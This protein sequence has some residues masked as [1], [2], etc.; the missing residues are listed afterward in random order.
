MTT[1]FQPIG[2]RY[3]F[4][5]WDEPGLKTTFQISVKH[6]QQY[7]AYSNMQ[8]KSGVLKNDFIVTRFMKS[9]E[10]SIY[11]VAIA[12]V[13]RNMTTAIVNLEGVVYIS[14]ISLEREYMYGISQRVMNAMS[15]YIE[16]KLKHKMDQI[17]I[18]SMPMDN[19]A[20]WGLTVY[21]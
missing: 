19:V 1:T 3:L 2:A 6:P 14:R 4:P 17:I 13:P 10:M 18:P 7:M 9:P 12:I 16:F 8:I 15:S 11:H 20:N 21:K 5:C